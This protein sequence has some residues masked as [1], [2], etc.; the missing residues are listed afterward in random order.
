MKFIFT[1]CDARSILAECDTR[2]LFYRHKE[3]LL[4]GCNTRSSSA[5]ATQGIFLATRDVNLF[6]WT[7]NNVNC[8]RRRHKIKFYK[9]A[10]QSQGQQDSTQRI[11][12][13]GCYRRS[14]F[15]RML[16][17]V[18]HRK[19]RH[20]VNF[21]RIQRKVNFNRMRHNVSKSRIRHKVI[22]AAYD[23]RSVLSVYGTR[24]VLFK[25]SV[26]GLNSVFFLSV[27]GQRSLL[28]TLSRGREYVI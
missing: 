18:S 12:I 14:S 25:W 24:S 23:E 11:F 8:V 13:V 28:F 19:I 17:K 3:Y 26:I 10:T 9:E 22:L 2:S 5:A 7:Q 1:R 15:S 4:L 21:S 16:H 20:N 27:L 6:S